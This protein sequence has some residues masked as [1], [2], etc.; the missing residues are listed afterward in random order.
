MRRLIFLILLV[1]GVTVS[2]ITPVTEQLTVATTVVGFS[3]NRIAGAKAAFCR[4]ETAEIRYEFGGSFPTTTVGF[5]WE[6]GEE[7]T[8]ANTPEIPNMLATFLAIRTGGT[9]GQLDCKYY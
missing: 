3:P 8:L 7:K 4:L 6:V 5:L 1:G 9:S 2:A